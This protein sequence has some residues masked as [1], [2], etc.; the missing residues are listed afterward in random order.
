MITVEEAKAKMDGVV[1][2]LATIFKEDLSLDVDATQRN[3]QWIIDQGAKPG[4]T[5]FIAVG[6]GGDFTVMTTEERK[7]AIKAIA[8]VAIPNDIPTFASV[9]STDIGTT[10][11]LCQWC[12]EVGV[13]LVQM[14][15][16]YY[17][18][19]HKG[20]IIAWV[21]EVAKHTDVGF[22]AYS[23]WYS[24]S[25]YDMTMDVAEEI[26][27]VPNTV[28]VKWGS[29]NI[30]N[31][32]AG[33][34]YFVPRAAVVN[35]GPLSVYGHQLGVKAWVSHVPNFF[36]QHSWAVHELMTAGNYDEAQRVLDAFDSE[37]G[38]IRAAITSQTAGEGVFVK[39]FMRHMG[40]P[41]GPSRLP[42]RDA[43]VTPE[44]NERIRSLMDKAPAIV[45]GTKV[46]L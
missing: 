29:P 21:N 23:H 45:E 25:K 1:I 42:S 16:A 30:A 15:S 10:I 27:K 19:V 14:S 41:S 33:I 31:Y 32:I 18:D 2:P 17:Y 7:T 36:P 28:A 44:I 12:E 46:A 4:N 9:Q 43:A 34:K 6:S 22:A 26:L 38:Q 11:E 40:R 3:V 13:D 20:D 39:P 24:G 35:N 5:V 8:E 37:Y